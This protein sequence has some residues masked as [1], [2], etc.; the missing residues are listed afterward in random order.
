LE[1]EQAGAEITSA[2][3]ETS[4]LLVVDHL[5]IAESGRCKGAIIA[6]ECVDEKADSMT[7]VPKADNDCRD[8]TSRRL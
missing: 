8:R 6:D 1:A 2:S 4:P 3:L 5:W 7:N